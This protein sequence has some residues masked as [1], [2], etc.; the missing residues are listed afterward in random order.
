M[1]PARIALPLFLVLAVIQ[2]A[3]PASMIWSREQTLQRGTA[4]KFRTGAV[5]PYDIFRGR[6]VVLRFEERTAPWMDGEK[7]PPGQTTVYAMIEEG[8][9]G[10]ARFSGATATRPAQGDYLKLRAGRRKQNDPIVQLDVPFDRYYLEESV[11][12]EAEA[13]YRRHSRGEKRN[14]YVIL[15]VRAGQGV[16]EELYVAGKPILEAIA[17]DAEE[18]PGS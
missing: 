3:A 17:A 15:R 12:P 4:F 11:A 5:D 9:D 13:L 1:K 18:P 2:L 7:P 8:E 10:F 14:A 6:Y 16:L